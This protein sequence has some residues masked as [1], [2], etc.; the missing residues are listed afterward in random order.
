MTA[1]DDIR[2]MSEALKQ[3][4]LAEKAN[5]VPI[6]AVLVLDG[7]IISRGRNQ[8]ISKNDPCGHAEIVCLRRAAKKLKNYRLSGTILYTTVEP[9]AMCA[10]AAVWARVK[11]IVYG[12]ADSKA[13]AC[14]SVLNFSSIKLNHRFETVSG[15]LENECRTIL[16]QFFKKKR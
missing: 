10:G 8:S 15:V 4:R 11:K 9:C 7:K 2:W 3:A 16:Q 1:S 14:G 13:G 5:E 12:C 6:G